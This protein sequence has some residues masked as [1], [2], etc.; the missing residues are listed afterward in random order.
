MTTEL[1][2]L[3]LTALLTRGALYSGGHWIRIRARALEAFRLQGRVDIAFA[4]VGQ[5]RQSSSHERGREYRVVSSRRPDRQGG[6]VSTSITALSATIFFYARA[7]HAVLH[8]S[9]FGPVHGSHRPLPSPGL[10]S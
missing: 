8:I 10:L 9:G 2:Y 1:F 3:L 7:A 5:S 4:R 6:R